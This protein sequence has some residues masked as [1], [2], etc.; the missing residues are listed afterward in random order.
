MVSNSIF[1]VEASPEAVKPKMNACSQPV[2]AISTK[3]LLCAF[4]SL[5]L[6][7]T[8]KRTRKPEARNTQ[9]GT[10]LKSLWCGRNDGKFELQAAFVIIIVYLALC[11]QL[12]SGTKQLPQETECTC[13]LSNDKDFFGLL[14]Q[15]K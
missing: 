3:K 12:R 13:C 6:P 1:Q 8:L 10:E 5:N 9:P 4:M 2:E 7:I 15:D 14:F 11:D